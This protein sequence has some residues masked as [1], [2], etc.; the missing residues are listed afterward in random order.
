MKPRRHRH[1]RRGHTLVELVASL[2]SAGVL[3][4]GIASTLFTAMRASNPANTPAADLLV[5]AECV[6]EIAA[7]LQ[8]AQAISSTSSRALTATVP[9]RNDADVS[10]ETIRYAWSGVAGEPLTRTYNGVPANVVDGVR[11]FAIEYF[12]STSAAEWITVRIQRTA[13]ASTTV[14][15]SFPI[16]NRP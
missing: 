15:T 10:V 3:M 1:F 8:Y 12:P 5:G 9:D 14:E 6:A 13:N 4:A 16:L 2:A 7:E 11:S